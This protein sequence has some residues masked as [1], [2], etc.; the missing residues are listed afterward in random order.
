MHAA[1]TSTSHHALSNAS[2]SPATAATPK[3]A[4]AA[5]LT[6]FGGTRPDPVRRSGPERSSSVPR[7]PSE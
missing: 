6:R 1:P 4:N 3:H 7:T 5:A 2:A